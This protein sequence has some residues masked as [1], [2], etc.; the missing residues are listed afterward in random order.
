CRC[1]CARFQC[2]RSSVAGR[3]DFPWGSRTWR[4]D[5]TGVAIGATTRRSCK[6]GNAH[7]IHVTSRN[8]GTRSEGHRACWSAHGPRALHTVISVTRDVVFVMV[9]GGKGTRTG[10]DEL[11]QFRWV[12]GKPM[13]LH[14]V[15]AFQE[16]ND[17]AMV[18]VVLPV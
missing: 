3:I 7:G 12:A 2:V 18:V 14:S 4:R 9:A 13:L 8:S 15:Q 5:Q 1:S 17:V 10:G 6:D 16:R 11:K